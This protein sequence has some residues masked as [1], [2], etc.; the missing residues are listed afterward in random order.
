MHHHV[1]GHN[2]RIY[3]ALTNIMNCRIRQVHN[4]CVDYKYIIPL[5]YHICISYIRIFHSY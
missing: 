2:I 3:L 5:Y 4:N 1:F